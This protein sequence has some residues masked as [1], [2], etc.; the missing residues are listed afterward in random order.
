MATKEDMS[1]IGK[2]NVRRGKTHERKIA[3]LLKDWSGEE[4]R[5]RRVEG[6]DSNVIDRESTAD[7]IPA[8]KKIIFS[9]EAKCGAVSTLDGLLADP[10][11]NKFTV[12]WHQ[13]CYDAILLS[14]ALN[15]DIWPML[16]FKPHISADWVAIPREPFDRLILKDK[17][18]IARDTLW[19]NNIYVDVYDRTGP[20]S[21]NTSNSK[22]N[23]VLVPLNLHPCYFIRWKDF[24]DNI[25]PSSIFY[26][27]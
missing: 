14:K 23:P 22:K 1:R 9:I 26:E 6:R 27:D 17:H 12:W 5:R 24:A 25:D 4:F 3:N 15:K 18:G 2:S 10:H 13:A 8:N 11:K 21:H 7:V 19:F 20:I 16:F